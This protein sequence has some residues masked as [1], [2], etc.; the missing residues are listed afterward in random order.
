L[1]GKWTRGRKLEVCFI[2]IFSALIIVLFYALI[3]MNGLVLGND[4]AVHLAKAQIFLK[5]GQIPLDSIGWIPPLFEILLAM[6][7]SISGASSAGQLIF[8]VKALA[9]AIDLLLFL[10]VYLVGSKFFNKKTGAVAAVFLAMCDSMY[11]VNTWGG[12]TTV[13]GI[14][15]LLLL[16]YYSYLAGKQSGYLVVA[17]L[18]S[19]AAVLSHQLT[20]FLAVVIMLPIQVL[21]LI[22]F[23]GFYLKGF[24]AIILGGAIAFFA[25]YFQAIISYLDIAIYHVFFS[26]KAY[27]LQIPYTSFQSFLLYFGFIQF[28]A[29]GGI[30]I[31][32]FLLKRQK[33]MILFV[34]LMLSLFVPLFFAESY[35][36]GFLLPFEWFTYYLISP[37]VILAAVCVVFIEEKLKAYIIRNKHFVHKKWLRIAAISLIAL[38]SCPIIFFHINNTYSDVMYDGAF[39]SNS[40]INAYDAGVWLNQNYPDTANVVVTRNPGDW[41]PIFSGKN[42]ISQTY[43]WEGTNSIA[44]SVLNLDYEIQ[45]PQT[46]VKAYETNHY[47]TDEAC[48]SLN[49]VWSRVSYSSI[50]ADFVSFNQHGLNYSFALS[51]LNRTLS[52][53]D[54]NNPKKIEFRYFNNQVAITQT[55]FVQNDRYPFNVSW[56]ISP[57][58]GSISNATLYLTVYFDLQFHFDKAQVSHLMNWVNPWDMP[59]KTANGK[60]WATVNFTSS[61]MKSDHYLGLFDQQTQT[62]FTFNFTDLPDWVNIGALNNHQID[63]VRYQYTFNQISA[64][65]NV[66]RQY[67]VL[68][69]SK[70]SYPTLQPDELQNLFNLEFG[71][72][73]ITVNNYKEFIGENNIEFIVYDK[74]QMDGRTS[75][76][77]GSSFLPQITQSQFLELVYSNSRYDIFKILDNYNQTQVWK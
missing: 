32:F 64:N 30:G 58:N 23:K 27:L 57:L 26:V 8:L 4:P 22:K 12:Y 17:F 10:S 29:I 53:Y 43:D 1:L 15:F 70:D 11:E 66:T 75:F 51:D 33:K 41:F 48:V 65:Q 21:M 72:F 16:F 7:I 49:Q 36:F 50:D 59:S 76:T 52:F 69:L 54:Q 19:F 63:A 73:N 37:I 45:G 34:T 31:S 77:L 47:V 14:S 9:V 24:I 68:T 6:A 42:V 74:D 40:D 5:T 39:N 61:D 25:F 71:Q 28:F 67:Q 55:I 46:Q 56:S 3:S 20:A 60:E 18:V 2:A 62:A 38:T 35:I 44:Q 13:L